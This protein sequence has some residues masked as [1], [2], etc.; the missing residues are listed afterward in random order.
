MNDITRI[1]KECDFTIR[2]RARRIGYNR[3][4]NISWD[5][6]SS[7]A[8]KLINMPAEKIAVSHTIDSYGRLIVNVVGN[9]LV[10][11]TYGIEV[12]GYY[13]NG[14]WRHQIAPAFEIV[15]NSTEENYAL[16]ETDDCTIDF[17]ITLG[18]TYVSTRV[19]DQEKAVIEQAA[20]DIATIQEDSQTNIKDVKVD[21]VSIVSNKVANIDTSNFGHVDDVKIN[22]VSIV[23][24]KVANIDTSQFGHVDDV[25]VNNASVVNNKVANI[26]V[27]VNISE[28]ENDSDFATNDEV[29]ENWKASRM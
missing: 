26:T 18:E 12:T 3:Y 7:L 15:N 2:I 19:F 9:S 10:C 24:N 20:L 27:P 5:E 1:T 16:N 23:S 13:N 22:D 14:N 11:N 8:V 4:V 28:L 17:N 6:I 21:G 25:K 29:D